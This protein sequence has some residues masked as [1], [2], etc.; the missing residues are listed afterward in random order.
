MGVK[1]ANE[2]DSG[3]ASHCLLTYD[4][5]AH[6]VRP[7]FFLTKRQEGEFRDEQ[8]QYLYTNVNTYV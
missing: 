3:N 6:F 7:K 2:T 1:T 5:T 8:E 4:L